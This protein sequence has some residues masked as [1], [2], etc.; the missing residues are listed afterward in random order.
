M[1]IIY[2]PKGPA[3]EYAPLALNIYKGCTHGCRYCYAP[4]ATRT[5]RADYIRAANPKRNVIERVRKD[6]RAMARSGDD[7]EILISFVGDP[8][9]PAEQALVLTRQVVSILI[10]YG[11]RFT[12]LTKGALSLVTRDFDLLAG[13]P[14]CRLG[15]SCVWGVEDQE[16]ADFWEPEAESIINRYFLLQRARARGIPTWVSLEPVIDPGSAM[17]VIRQFDRVVDKWMIGKINHNSYLET[18]VDWSAFRR[19][20]EDLLVSLGADYYLKDSL[21]KEMR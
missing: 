21:R 14:K 4:G 11:L 6:A 9:Q 20:A 10:E 8:Y 13:Y 5:A 3:S 16:L 18:A 15:V 7:R 17:G 12:V 2:E 19:R 1:N